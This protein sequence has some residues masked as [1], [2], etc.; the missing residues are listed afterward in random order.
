MKR[1]V[2]LARTVRFDSSREDLQV[3]SILFRDEKTKKAC[4]IFLDWLRNN[5]AAATRPQISQFGRDLQ[6]GRI[7]AGFRYNRAN[8]YDPILRRMVNLGLIGIRGSFDQQKGVVEKYSPIIQPI[9]KNSP[10]RKNFWHIAWAI[11][12]NWNDLWT[13]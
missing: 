9:P 3:C 7:E 1:L 2:N 8:L 4:R 6:A 13:A 5:G 10:S 11:C 12:K